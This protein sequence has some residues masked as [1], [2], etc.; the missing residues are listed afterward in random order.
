MKGKSFLDTNIFIY[1]IDTSPKE[2]RKREIA[3]ELV[4]E[5]I[6][7][8]SGVISIQVLQEFYQV[9]TQKI[10]R[11]LS[12]EE[13]LEFMQYISIFQTVR[14]DYYMIVSAVH[15]HKNKKLSFWDAMI[16]Q[17]AI[18][19]SCSQVLSEDLQD[20]FRINQT[21]LKNPFKKQTKSDS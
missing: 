18:T 15:L 19:A 2:K 16:L 6:I 17:S 14:P 20:G 13:A 3:K 4:R 10:K 12:T 11:P 21:V 5:H 8:E 7:N 1:A 9:S